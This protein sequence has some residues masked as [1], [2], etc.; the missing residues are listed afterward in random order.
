M[1]PGIHHGLAL[2]LFLCGMARNAF[3]ALGSPLHGQQGPARAKTAMVQGGAV[4]RQ[5]E[6]ESIC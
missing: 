5:I 4:R 2:R 6:M 3:S 1:P